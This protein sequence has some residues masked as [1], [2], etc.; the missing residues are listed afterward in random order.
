MAESQQTQPGT[1]APDKPKT[2]RELAIEAQKEQQAIVAAKRVEYL[3]ALFELE[4][5]GGEDDIRG[6]IAE[7]VRA[8]SN[9]IDFPFLTQAIPNA[10]VEDREALAKAGLITIEKTGRTVKLKPVTPKPAAE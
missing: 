8:F 6:S 9:G 3:K 5:I 10:T 2:K 4:E 1:P 7:I